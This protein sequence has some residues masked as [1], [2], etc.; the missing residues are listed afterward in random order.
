MENIYAVLGMIAMLLVGALGA[1]ALNEP[2]VIET[3]KVV[4]QDKLVEKDCP[5]C[6]CDCPN[7][8]IPEMKVENAD[9]ELLNDFL[10]EEFSE[11][12]S[13][14]EDNATHYATEELEDDDYEVIVDYLKESVEG[15]DEDKVD[16]S[17]DDVDTTVTK[18]GLDEDEDKRA[19]V[20][21]E[22]E[23]E[24]ELEEG[25]RDEFEKD[26]VVTYDVLFDEGDFSDEEVEL[27][28]IV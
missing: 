18:L 23:V 13:A 5:E 15:L 2:Q 8:T 4:T 7:V 24:Y 20:E 14:I 3:Q 16:V 1:V 21:F 11:E 26:L 28:S 9:N 17:I 6:K 19:R 27:V 12:Y 25:V 10:E 22:V